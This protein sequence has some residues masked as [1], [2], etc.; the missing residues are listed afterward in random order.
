MSD[1]AENNPAN[2]SEWGAPQESSHYYD[3]VVIEDRPQL[4]SVDSTPDTYFPQ[5]PKSTTESSITD[6]NGMIAKLKF[7]ISHL[8]A[9]LAHQSDTRPSTSLSVANTIRALIATRKSLLE[10]LQNKRR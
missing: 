2:R 10:S 3:D 9:W 7:E 4:F 1:N 6:K 5:K 8:E